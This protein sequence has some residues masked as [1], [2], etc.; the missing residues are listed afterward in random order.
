MPHY[1]FADASMTNGL[2]F[3][4][5]LRRT[6]G[7]FG[8]LDNP[9]PCDGSSI[10]PSHIRNRKR[11]KRGSSVQQISWSGH[12]QVAIVETSAGVRLAVWC[13]E[14]DEDP[15]QRDKRQAH[16]MSA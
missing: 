15:G 11:W 12:G 14:L 2:T 4:L 16:A 7:L 8:L 6:S 5:G 3:R 10:E 9:P 13:S 1:G